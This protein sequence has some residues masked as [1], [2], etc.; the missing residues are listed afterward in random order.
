MAG[1]IEASVVDRCT[2]V[3]VRCSSGRTSDDVNKDCFN[4]ANTDPRSD[5]FS[6]STR[7]SPGRH[8]ATRAFEAEI[9]RFDEHLSEFSLL[10]RRS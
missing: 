1:S 2:V 4:R 8:A 6:R 3:S 10:N 9:G 5:A 7:V